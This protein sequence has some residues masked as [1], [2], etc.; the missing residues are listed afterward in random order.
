M[1]A[2]I[3]IGREKDEQTPKRCKQE[4]VEAKTRKEKTGVDKAKTSKN[5]KEK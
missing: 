3:Q 5:S 4:K 2:E 1:N